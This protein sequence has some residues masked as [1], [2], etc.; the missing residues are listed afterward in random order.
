MLMLLLLFM[1]FGILQLSSVPTWGQ[2]ARPGTNFNSPC[3]L[4]VPH[5][6]Y[7]TQALVG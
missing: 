2:A 1:I 7:I 6:S 4:Q 3:I 5:L